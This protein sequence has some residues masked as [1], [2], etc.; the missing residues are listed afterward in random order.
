MNINIDLFISKNPDKPLSKALTEGDGRKLTG[1]DR[2]LF[3]AFQMYYKFSEWAEAKKDYYE[4]S[5][6]NQLETL[7][8]IINT[9]N[10]EEQGI[11]ARLYASYLKLHFEKHCCAGIRSEIIMKLYELGVEA[12]DA[13][14]KT[15][16]KVTAYAFAF[17][18]VAEEWIMSTDKALVALGGDMIRMIQGVEATIRHCTSVLLDEYFDI[19]RMFCFDL[20]KLI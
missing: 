19:E 9:G 8:H 20:Y 11:A 3:W 17:R 16:G 13:S 14:G 5:L 6:L 10:E 1:T 18:C 15:I 7:E 12:H 2:Q 4:D